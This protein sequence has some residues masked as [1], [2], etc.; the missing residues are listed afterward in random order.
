MRGHALLRGSLDYSTTKSRHDKQYNDKF[1][2]SWVVPKGGVRTG[3][4]DLF[5]RTSKDFLVT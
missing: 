5:E 2:F 4:D 1:R 3:V